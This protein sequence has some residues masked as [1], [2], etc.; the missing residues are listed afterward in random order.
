MSTR[1]KSIA[2]T[3]QAQEDASLEGA[4]NTKAKAKKT[5]QAK[6]EYRPDRVNKVPVKGWFPHRVKLELAEKRQEILAEAFND[7]FKEHGR[8]ELASVV[9]KD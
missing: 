7:L 2:S 3:L 4:P 6:V 5:Q 9:D 8:A 1:R